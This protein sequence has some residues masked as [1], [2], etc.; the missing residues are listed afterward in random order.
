MNKDAFLITEKRPIIE[1]RSASIRL[2]KQE[3]TTF[4]RLS[5]KR[6]LTFYKRDKNYIIS[7]DK[8]KPKKTDVSLCLKR[9]LFLNRNK[10]AIN[11]YMTNKI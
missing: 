3:I 5:L 2:N 1:Y 7:T 9:I 6:V 10:A 4:F 8:N 11:V